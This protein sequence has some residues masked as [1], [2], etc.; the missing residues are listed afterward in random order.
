MSDLTLLDW[1]RLYRLQAENQID[2]ALDLIYNACSSFDVKP[3]FAAINAVLAAVE[4]DRITNTTIAIAFLS[5]PCSMSDRLPS[6]QPLLEKVR[7]WLKARGEPKE[8]IDALLQ[9]FERPPMGRL[10]FI[11]QELF[12]IKREADAVKPASE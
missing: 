4:L 1:D 6:Y 11:E 7:V 9:G 8:R 10:V 3:D 2:D 5:A 12:F